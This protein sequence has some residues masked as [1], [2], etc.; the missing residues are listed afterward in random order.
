MTWGKQTSEQDALDQLN[1]SFDEYAPLPTLQALS[2]PL[3]GW[4]GP[5]GLG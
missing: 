2:T 5:S 4:R 1:L 3:P